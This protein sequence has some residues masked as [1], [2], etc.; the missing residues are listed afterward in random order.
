[1]PL[2]TDLLKRTRASIAT[3][4]TASTL[5]VPVQTLAPAQGPAKAPKLKA[6]AT[7][8]SAAKGAAAQQLSL[9]RQAQQ[10]AAGS[11]DS[12]RR[13]HWADFNG[14]GAGAGVPSL[15]LAARRRSR[16]ARL[17][18]SADG[19]DGALDSGGS[20]GDIRKRLI[21]AMDDLW[22]EQ[23]QLAD[24][25]GRAAK[26]LDMAEARARSV[27]PNGNDELHSGTASAHKRAA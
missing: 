15:S 7:A 11:P 4:F 6:K 27:R 17:A 19:D 3:P 2:R 18:R 1:M 16:V 13:V 9:V 12:E 26:A 23:G 25:A 5:R 20:I 24:E 14:G 21:E 8:S 22:K 10:A